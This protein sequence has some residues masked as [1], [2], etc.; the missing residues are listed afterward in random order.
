M[1]WKLFFCSYH[2]VIVVCRMCAVNA[3]K[4]KLNHSKLN[5]YEQFHVYM[6]ETVWR[7]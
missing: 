6:G 2:A 7:K 3:I 1:L 4:Q 5:R